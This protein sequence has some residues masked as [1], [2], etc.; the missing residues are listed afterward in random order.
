MR[1]LFVF[2]V[3]SLLQVQPFH[4]DNQDFIQHSSDSIKRELFRS[5]E[6]TGKNGVYKVTGEIRSN[7]REFYYIVED[8]HNELI[9]ETRQKVN[10]NNS[11]W[12]KFSFTFTLRKENIPENGTVTLYLF[13]KNREGK[14]LHIYPFVLR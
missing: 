9:T 5:V 7:K 2:T 8:G 13:D 1:M 4:I 3:I 10:T 14:K 12:S 6:A 11:Q